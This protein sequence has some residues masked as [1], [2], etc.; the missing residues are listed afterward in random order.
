M[1]PASSKEKSRCDTFEVTDALVFNQLTPPP[2]SVGPHRRGG[3]ESPGC[4]G[5]RPGKVPGGAAEVPVALRPPV[6]RE[7]GDVLL[8][9]LL[10][11]PG[12]SAGF[13]LP[14]HQPHVLLLLPAG[15]GR[16]RV[17]A[18]RRRQRN[19][20]A[21][22]P[23]LRGCSAARGKEMYCSLCSLKSSL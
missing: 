4:P 2:S 19:A 18:D 17:H 13:P 8:V 14:Q 23:R 16:Y 9:Q 12:A 10:E 21:P 20:L 15:E 3:P 1:S 5:G 6:L 22:S 11:G 7:T